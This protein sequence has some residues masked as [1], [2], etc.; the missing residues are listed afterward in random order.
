MKYAV[1]KLA[2]VLLGASPL[3]AAQAGVFAP[4]AGSTYSDAVADTNPG[5]VGWANGY[6]NYVIGG[7]V[8]SQ[9]QTPVKSVG[10][11]GNSNGLNEG[12]A[13]DIV[14]LG[15]GGS[16]VMT[17]DP[18]IVDGNGAD[19]AVF[20]NSFS[21][22]FLELAKVEV[23][24]DGVNFVQFPAFSMVP[25]PVGGF[26]NLDPTDLEQLAGKY[27]GGYG[28][29]FDLSQLAGN[30]LL[31]LNNI[32]FVRVVDVTGD[33]TAVNDISLEAV[34]HW[35]NMAV[36]D[37][38]AYVVDAVNAAPAV[39]Y[40]PF[41]T[42]SSAGFDLDA[43]AVLNQRLIVTMDV[44]PADPDNNIDP[45][46]TEVIPVAV[47]SSSVADGDAI[48][49]DATQI[50]PSTLLFGYTEATNVSTPVNSDVDGDGN[51]DMTVGFNTQDTGILCEDTETVLLG[52]TLGG[53]V[54]SATDF[55]TTSEC[56][57]GGCH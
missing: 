9:F 38:P 56:D 39:I 37:L 15:R 46:S 19:F 42:V 10:A 49:F 57:D 18:P 30:P 27:R 12:Y 47:L 28:T 31:D 13:F 3:L 48:D 53:E 2:L 1:Q 21:N 50:D 8:D 16:I 26:G 14:T 4:A 52:E 11:A 43:V 34:A 20:E 35:A 6:Q 51:T 22:T 17:F 55:I 40:D 32:G 5:I 7:G 54:F 41:P 45:D 25:A 23:S 44:K 24:S 29:P 33:G 36:G